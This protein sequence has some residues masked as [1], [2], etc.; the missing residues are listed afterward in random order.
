VEYCGVATK[1]AAVGDSDTTGDAGGAELSLLG[2]GEADSDGSV[3]GNNEHAPPS[4]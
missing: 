1:S 2:L 4:Q 3:S